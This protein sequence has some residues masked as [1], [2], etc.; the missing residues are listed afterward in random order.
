MEW[1]SRY[2]S[3]RVGSYGL[4]H[5]GDV[6]TDYSVRRGFLSQEDFA[7]GA[8]VSKRTVDYWETNMYLSDME[9]RIFLAKLLRIPPALLGLTVYS[10]LDDTYH[11]TDYTD[12][13]KRMTE[14][15]EEDSYY[16]YE[17]ILVLGW[18]CLRKGGILQVAE[19]ITRRLVKLQ[20]IVEA[21]PVE[22][23]EAWQTLLFQYYRLYAAFARHSM[24]ATRVQNV[25]TAMSLA[26]E[27][28]D[29]E[30]IAT[31]YLHRA[32]LYVA[33]NQIE[34]AKT[35][36]AHAL[37]Y[38]GR[39]RSPLKGSI[40]LVAAEIN[41]HQGGGKAIEEENKRLHGMAADLAYHLK[42]EHAYDRTFA[43]LNTSAV[44]H[45]RAKTLIAL[46]E[47]NPQNKK[48][49]KDAENELTLAKNTLTPE[50]VEWKLFFS[51]TESTLRKVQGEITQSAIAGKAALKT[52]R[53]LSSQSGIND[54]TNLYFDLKKDH[55]NNFAV[56]SL[57]VELGIF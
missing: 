13:L 45:E 51:L 29:V 48:H 20:A 28:E 37:T 25:T 3:Y 56:I 52:A 32:H 34:E 2:G 24:E 17:D 40:Y 57:G 41:S 49:L 10:V 54:T 5:M 36:I 30:L 50:L 46:Y 7:T 43:I 27:L 35:D 47:C 8:N 15:A 26:E 19:R 44:H 23:K 31:S 9:R 42:D 53:L 38:T 22:E 39:V 18:E 14:L 4:P 16:A 55:P 12:K 11:I 1:W 6:I 33:L 21:C